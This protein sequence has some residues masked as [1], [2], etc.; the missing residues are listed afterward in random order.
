MSVLETLTI[1][2]VPSPKLPPPPRQDEGMSL[3]GPVSEKDG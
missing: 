2:S 3:L 1:S